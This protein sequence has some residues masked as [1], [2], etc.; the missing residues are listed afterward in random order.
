ME[1]I[2][3]PRAP[4]RGTYHLRVRFKRQLFGSVDGI[5]LDQFA[6][7]DAYDLGVSLACYLM[8]IGAV[9][10]VDDGS[11]ATILPTSK[12]LFA[13]IETKPPATVR[14]ETE[15]TRSEAA[16]R[17]RRNARRPRATGKPK[18]PG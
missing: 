17:A 2:L 10:P 9:D 3:K 11:P 4:R 14:T 16:D 12:R 13:P 18:R 1:R 5:R 15:F 7:G 8:A 6:V